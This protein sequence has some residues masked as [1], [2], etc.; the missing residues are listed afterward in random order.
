MIVYIVVSSVLSGAFA[1]LVVAIATASAALFISRA[2]RQRKVRYYTV[3]EAF[4]SGL[5]TGVTMTAAH[6]RAIAARQHPHVEELTAR[7][8]P[9]VEELAE[10]EEL[11]AAWAALRASTG[12]P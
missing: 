1:G 5:A 2:R 3:Q 8:H 10:V 12:R 9:H 11:F 7:Q 6:R 4:A